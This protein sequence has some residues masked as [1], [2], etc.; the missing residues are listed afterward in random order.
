MTDGLGELAPGFLL[1]L[2][3]FGKSPSGSIAIAGGAAVAYGN[4]FPLRRG[5]MSGWEVKFTSTGTILVKVELE[6]GNQRPVTE[7]VADA[8]WAIPDNKVATPIF[9][10]I[11]DTN[12][13]IAAYAPDVTA[14]GRLKFTGSGAND[15]STKCT[16]AKVYQ[17]KS[18]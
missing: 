17:L 14:Y 13:H 7:A 11:A 16:V 10:A 5:V 3:T 1:D 8:T 15:A 12:K 18:V 6:Q 9:A 2:L 4:S